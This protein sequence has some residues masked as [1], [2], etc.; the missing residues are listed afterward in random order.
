MTSQQAVALGQEAARR[1][2]TTGRVQLAP[3]L[4]EA[5]LTR[6]EERFG[7]EFADDHRAFLATALPVGGSWPDWR[8]DDPAVLAERLAD[9]VHGVLFDVEWNGFWHQDWGPRP[10]DAPAALAVAGEQLAS[11]P[12][13]VPVYSH[14]YL[15]AGRGG[16]G[17]PVLSMSQTDV[18]VYGN[19]LPDYVEAEFGAGLSDRPEL[20][21]ATPT[22]PF[23]SWLAG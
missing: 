23:W 17:H 7:F 13:M 20:A 2:V 16:F 3:G 18:T 22:V 21:G 12:R 9:P 19:S 6:T 10:E 11:A 4:T 8:D 1:L 15:P 14:R 5:E